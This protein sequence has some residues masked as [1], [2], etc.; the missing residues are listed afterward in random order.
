MGEAL[1]QGIEKRRLEV[2]VAPRSMRF[3]ALAAGAAP[4]A[5]AALQRR[6]GGNAISEELA[7][8]QQSWR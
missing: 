2:D 7:R 4:A 1:A 5:M 6:L 8:G 3:G